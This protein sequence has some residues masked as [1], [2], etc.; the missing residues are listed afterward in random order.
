MLQR[1][2]RPKNQKN[3]KELSHTQRVKG[4][5]FMSLFELVLLAS[6][7]CVL[8]LFD[9]GFFAVDLKLDEEIHF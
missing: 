9:D 3:T 8:F 4:L 5:I 1:D 6:H 7:C 2:V